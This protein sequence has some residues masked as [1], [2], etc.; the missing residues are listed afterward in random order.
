MFVLWGSPPIPDPPDIPRGANRVW[1][2]SGVFPHPEVSQSHLIPMSPC[3]HVP[4]GG[5]GPWIRVGG[6]NPLLR[7]RPG[8]ILRSRSRL[9][10]GHPRRQRGFSGSQDVPGDHCG[11]RGWDEQRWAGGGLSPPPSRRSRYLRWVRGRPGCRPGGTGWSW[12]V[13]STPA[14]GTGSAG[15]MGAVSPEAGPGGSDRVP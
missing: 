10:P 13:G 11:N 12:G 1:V 8:S 5:I 6:G 14:T 3:P 4:P 15:G 2:Y 9:Y 7:P